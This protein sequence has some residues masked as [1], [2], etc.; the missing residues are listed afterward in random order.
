M[1]ADL[2]RW[3]DWSVQERLRNLY[4]TEDFNDP[5]IK[6]AIINYMLASANASPHGDAENPGKHIAE[7]IRYL[8]ELRTLDPKLVNDAERYFIRN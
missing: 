1:I 2:A 4:G 7:G 5:P 3:K 8:E 6:R